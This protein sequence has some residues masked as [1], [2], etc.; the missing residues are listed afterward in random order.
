MASTYSA[1]QVIPT[2]FANTFK[3]RFRSP[4]SNQLCLSAVFS[5]SIQP[6]NKTPAIFGWKIIGTCSVASLLSL[7]G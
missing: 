6:T 3:P 1:I 2:T 7:N 5:A 4:V